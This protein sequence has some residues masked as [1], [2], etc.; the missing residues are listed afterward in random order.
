[1]QLDHGDVVVVGE[2]EDAFAGVGGTDPEVVHPA[3]AADGHRAF[4]VEPVVAQ[5]VVLLGEW[6]GGERFRGLAVGV[7]RGVSVERAVWAMFVVMLT[8]QVE[9]MLQASEVWCWWSGGEPA[10]QGLVEAFDLALGLRVSRRSVLLPDTED[11]QQVLERVS[12]T[13]EAGCVDA[14]VVGER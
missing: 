11:R 3:A 2:R 6:P 5:P 4:L 12:A 13:T 10:L 9:L 7:A 14:P 8:E 1:M